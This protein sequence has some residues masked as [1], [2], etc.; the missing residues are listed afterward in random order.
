MHESRKQSRHIG[1]TPAE[2][3]QWISQSCAEQEEMCSLDVSAPS[4]HF[5]RI[6][7]RWRRK[8]GKNIN[9]NNDRRVKTN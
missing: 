4:Q 1:L 3:P 8:G 5:S 7:P 6:A 2:T 9:N